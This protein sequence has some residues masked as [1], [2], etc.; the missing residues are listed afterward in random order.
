[1]SLHSLRSFRMS[2]FTN[3]PPTVPDAAC[4]CGADE[5]PGAADDLRLPGNR[6]KGGGSELLLNQRQGQGLAFVT[7]ARER[8]RAESQAE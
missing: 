2:H 6:L 7:E 5:T 3:E 4:C 1:M 8:D